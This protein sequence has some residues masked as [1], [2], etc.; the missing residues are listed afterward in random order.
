MYHLGWNMS[1]YF[2][3]QKQD[4]ATWL[5]KVFWDL[6]EA[7]LPDITKKL[8]DS[9]KNEYNIPIIKDIPKYLREQKS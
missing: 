3:F 8:H 2:G 9:T 5:Q 7:K 6:R 1:H 4:V